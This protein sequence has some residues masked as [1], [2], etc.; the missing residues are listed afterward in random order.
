MLTL[1]YECKKNI[2]SNLNKYKIMRKKHKTSFVSI[3]I[4]V[5]E[6]KSYLNIKS[7]QY[8]IEI[9]NYLISTIT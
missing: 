1:Y 4:Q 3:P 8:N 6:Y 5:H 2:T 7:S 9:N